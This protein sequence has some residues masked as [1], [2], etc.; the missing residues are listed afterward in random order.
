MA[1]DVVSFGR[2]LARVVVVAGGLLEDGHDFSGRQGGIG[3]E[4]QGD[5]AGGGRAAHARAREPGEFIGGAFELYVFGDAVRPVAERAERGLHADAGR[6]DVGLQPLVEG[7]AV[8]RE[9]GEVAADLIAAGVDE[10]GIVGPDGDDALRAG[11]LLDAVERVAGDP[12][13]LAGGGEVL[14]PVADI[15]GQVGVVPGVDAACRGGELEDRIGV[16]GALVDA[17]LHEGAAVGGVGRFDRDVVEDGVVSIDHDLGLP[18]G[19]AVR[20][21][22]PFRGAHRVVGT[23]EEGDAHGEGHAGLAP[24]REVL[25]PE[26]RVGG[27]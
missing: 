24:Q 8:G 22:D 7:G 13:G 25:A 20:G 27:D 12:S 9:P 21:V 3:F 14:A 16:G 18:H 4:H 26:I 6:A 11:G 5:D 23:V 15:V 17:E 19:G 2:E 10:V 1:P